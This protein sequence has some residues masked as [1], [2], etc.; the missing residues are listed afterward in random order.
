MWGGKNK[1]WQHFGKGISATDEYT[2]VFLS[3]FLRHSMMHRLHTKQMEVIDLNKFKVIKKPVK[4]YQAM[5][6]S[7]NQ[8]F[9]FLV[10][11]N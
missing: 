11:K 8:P 7:L 10:C 2:G 4:V 5:R 3:A 1:T 9:V 6:E